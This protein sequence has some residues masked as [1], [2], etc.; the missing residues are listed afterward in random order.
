M[1]DPIKPR[2]GTKSRLKKML[3]TKTAAPMTTDGITIPRVCSAFVPTMLH[4]FGAGRD[5]TL[6]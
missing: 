1:G 6:V 4:I 3:A 2:R 5:N